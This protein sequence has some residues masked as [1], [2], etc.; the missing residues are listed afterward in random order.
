MATRRALVVHAVAGVR[1]YL[2]ELLSREGFKVEAVDSTFRCMARFVEQAA[3]LVVLGVGGIAESELELVRALKRE[4]SPPRVLVTFPTIKRDLAVRALDAGA[5]AYVLE[6]FYADELLGTVR[7]LSASPA[8]TGSEPGLGELALEVAHAIGNPLQVLT[9]LLGKDR[10]T[11]RE[12][13]T[14][15]PPHVERMQSVI[16]HL[17]EFAA[18]AEASPAD[19]V[20]LVP[21]VEGAARDAEL[22][23]ECAETALVVSADQRGYVAALG[24]IFR[25]AHVRAGEAAAVDLAKDGGS[26]VV[27]VALPASRLA[28][29]EP[30]RLPDLI[31]VVGPERDILPGLALARAL[32]ERQG[33]SLH[34]ERSG[35]QVL[36]IA[37]IP[38]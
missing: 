17:R 21:V 36:L 1:S 14:G 27:R 19:R 7:G 10:V 33:G 23:F 15:I 29:E 32:L 20:D 4:K 12:L 28:G 26:A 18:M 34:V 9:L 30:E 2:A 22:G 35:S 24:A 31:F 6:P 37:K 3:D 13:T 5:D 25:A 38:A 11:K 16:D 8:R